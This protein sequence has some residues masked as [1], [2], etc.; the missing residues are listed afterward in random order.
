MHASRKS[1][2][3]A[4]VAVLLNIVSQS[5]AGQQDLSRGS[6]RR[7]P[8]TRTYA[9]AEPGEKETHL[10]RLRRLRLEVEQLEEDVK[11]EQAESTTTETGNE[12][13]TT[14]TTGEK[15][16]GEV[17]P[18]VILQQLQL[19][20]GDLGGLGL[21]SSDEGVL[22]GEGEKEEKSVLADKAKASSSLLSKLGFGAATT[23][24]TTAGAATVTPP[25]PTKAKKE[26]FGGDAQ[27]EKRL[28]EVERALGASEADV[29]EVSLS[30]SALPSYF[31]D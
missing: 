1:P 27:L 31:S 3:N 8:S 6:S 10:E 18:G 29:D 26:T 24:S 28:A 25:S 4:R 16:R 12:T 30:G 11:R 23:D 2:R 19:L 9:I 15:K 13:T 22:E 21:G 5:R 20:R 7:L 17:T 14:T